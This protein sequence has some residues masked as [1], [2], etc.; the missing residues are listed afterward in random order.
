MKRK[1]LGKGLGKGYRNIIPRFDSFI[2]S[3][4]AQ[5]IKSKTSP[6][7]TLMNP[8]EYDKTF[9]ED[10]SENEVGYAVTKIKNDGSVDVYVKHDGDYEKTGKLIAHELNEIEIWDD[11]VYEGID[12]EHV[13][14]LAHNLNPVKVE[15]V[16]PVYN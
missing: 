13:E 2:H 14:K 5:G 3:L 12:P 4:S 1:G 11:L 9:E 7:I 16:S 6:N 10:Y 15:G 8:K